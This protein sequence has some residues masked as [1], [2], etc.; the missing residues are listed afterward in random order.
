[1]DQHLDSKTDSSES[2]PSPDIETNPSIQQSL[3]PKEVEIQPLVK[4]TSSAP[5]TMQPIQMKMRH[6]IEIY[7]HL[8]KLKVADMQIQNLVPK[9]PDPEPRDLI[10]TEHCH[11]YHNVDS[12]GRD[13]VYSTPTGGHFHKVDLVVN[14]KGEIC[15]AKC[16]SGPMQFI[17]K[18]KGRRSVKVCV[19]INAYDHHTHE[20]EYRGSDK[21]KTR[22]VSD[23]V[24]NAVGNMVAAEA[25]QTAPID[26]VITR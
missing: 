10:A 12:D 3:P 9:V 22:R 4:P 6:A 21:I 2:K 26:G 20:I 11:F 14:D 16:S 24:A 7:H 13:Q 1:M 17:R 19:S 18:K 5:V 8:F 25:Q 23:E 15:A